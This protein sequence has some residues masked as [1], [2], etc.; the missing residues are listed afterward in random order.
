VKRVAS[1]ILPLIV[2][3]RKA[4]A[5]LYQQIYDA[6][7]S[8]IVGRMLRPGQRVPST[9]TL[10]KELGV[11]RLPILNAYAQLLAEGYFQSRVGAGTVV[12]RSLPDQLPATSARAARPVKTAPSLRQLSRRGFTSDKDKNV[13]WLRGW[14][15]FGVS[16]VAFEHFP[17][18]V[19]NRLITRGCRRSFAKSLDYGEPMGLKKLRS[20]IA[21][22]VRTARGV[23]CEDD[24]IMV[25]SGSQQ[26]LDITARVLVNPGNSV[27]IEEPGYRFAHRLFSFHDCRVVPVPVDYEGMNVREGIRLARHARAALVTPSHQYPLGVTMSASRRLQLLDWAEQYGAWVIE[28]DYDSEFRYESMPIASLQGLD[29]NSRVIYI[30]TFSKVMFPSLRLG[31]IIVP[32]DLIQAFLS[33]RL[34]MD[35]APSYF[36]QAVMADFIEQSHFSRHIRRMRVVYG[37]RREALTASL[38]NAFGFRAEIAGGQAGMHLSVTLKGVRDQEIALRAANQNLWLLP[39]SSSYLQ[40]PLRQG[41]ILGFGSTSTGEMPAAVQKLKVVTNRFR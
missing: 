26:A 32:T 2:V 14:G 17:F 6:Y 24:Q 20:A 40:K 5:A 7:R 36:F 21:N 19:W 16:Q 4:P 13:P 30:G 31:Y 29:S 12:S 28:D 34:A 10:A 18:S 11:S 23:R 38:R 25:V 27:W 22:Y 3:D 8:A 35:I 41:F 9:R 15:P 33:M 39:L 1:A 37:E